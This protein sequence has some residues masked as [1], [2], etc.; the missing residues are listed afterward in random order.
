MMHVYKTVNKKGMII[1]LLGAVLFF[2]TADVRAENAGTTGAPFLKIGTSS[3]AES[4]GA[5][6]TAVV[7]DVDATYW[8][9]AGLMQLKRSSIGFTHL[10][11][12]EDIRYEYISYADKYDYIGAVGIGL[13]FLYLGDI[14]KTLETTTGD[15]D[16]IN[17]GG[18]FGASDLLVNFAWAGNLGLRENKVGVGVKIIQES[19]DD[20]QSFSFGVDLG[21]Q[22]LLSKTRWYRRL[23]KNSGVAYAIP[24]T[25]GISVKN[26]GTPVKFF[27]Q[28]DPLPLMV[29]LGLAYQFLDEDL[30]AALDLNYQ[31]VESMLTMH[32]GAEY[33]IHTGMRSAPD[34]SL[35]LALRAGYRTGYDSTTAPG[36]SFGAGVRYASLGLDYVFMPFGDLGV[37]HRVSLKFSWGSILKDKTPPKR[38]RIVK[39]KL[40]A[41]ERA[42]QERASMMMKSKRS[43]EDKVVVQKA[44]DAK[45][46]MTTVEAKKPEDQA[47]AKE[48]KEL[49]ASIQVPAGKK[50]VAPIKPGTAK[51]DSALIAKIARGKDMQQEQ[52]TRSKYIRRSQDDVIR[53]ARRETEMKNKAMDD[54]EAAAK[55]EAEG[56]ATDKGRM[57]TKTTVYFAQNSSKLD[58]R[59]FFALDKIAVSFDRFPQRTIL[60]HGYTSADES[61]KNALSLQRAKAVKDYL[62][63]IKS[64]P[65]N[66]VS[67]KGFGDKDP[68]ASNTDAK[69]RVRNRR[70]N[71]RLIKSGN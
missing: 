71:V 17:S 62:V 59:Y 67:I 33:W 44:P 53:A 52:R 39:R 2:G 63:Q 51:I 20:N 55:Q 57:V 65:S 9:P 46:A 1:W 32:V 58:D 19:I 69:Q 60:V 12:F 45:R 3:R 36:F 56:K 26:I 5:A 42:L 30:T 37:T 8:N 25:V 64:I 61:D 31:T 49:G 41:S 6:Y 15:Y 54:I 14:P 28:N 35:D 21:N 18:T 47:V 10:E 48:T 66:K 43:M 11:W 34:Q 7:D 4:M 70:V 27:N 22:L 40:T 13:G 50:G 23:A 68:E 24:S 16:D 38:R 29:G